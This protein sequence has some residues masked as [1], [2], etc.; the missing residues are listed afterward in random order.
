MVEKHSEVSAL[1]IG[2]PLV[3]PLLVFSDGALLIAVV[4][5]ASNEERDQR[6]EENDDSED[7]P[8]DGRVAA[9]IV[10]LMVGVRGRRKAEV[11]CAVFATDSVAQAVLVSQASLAV[12]EGFEGGAEVRQATEVAR[13]R[14]LVLPPDLACVVSCIAKLSMMRADIGD[15]LSKVGLLLRGEA[16][17]AEVG[18]RIAL[19]SLALAAL[20][21]LVE[22][23]PFTALEQHVAAVL[24]V[25]LIGREFGGPHAPV[26]AELDVLD[27]AP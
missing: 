11:A 9:H 17:V 5:L 10:A 27:A 18:S 7:D 16:V 4:V 20:A 3:E 1:D 21:L 26:S 8:E 15:L 19:M 14:L 24:N 6:S 22:L 25:G 12:A 2:R 23:A 13:A